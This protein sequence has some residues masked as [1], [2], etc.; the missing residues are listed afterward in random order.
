MGNSHMG[1]G[2]STYSLVARELTYLLV[3]GLLFI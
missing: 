1:I 3:P 2:W